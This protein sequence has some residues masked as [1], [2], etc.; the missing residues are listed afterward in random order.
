MYSCSIR[1]APASLS[2]ARPRASSGRGAARS[3]CCAA[4]GP[5]P[6]PRAWSACAITGNPAVAANSA[7]SPGDRPAWPRAWAPPVPAELEHREL[8]RQPAGAAPRRAGNRNASR[9]ASPCSARKI[10][11]ASSVG[12]Q[13]RRAADPARPGRAGRPGSVGSS[14][15]GCQKNRPAGN[16]NW[17]PV[18]AAPHAPRTPARRAG[19]GCGSRPRLPWCSTFRSNLSTTAGVLKSAARRSLIIAAPQ[20]TTRCGA[21]SNWYVASSTRGQSWPRSSRPRGAACAPRPGPSPSPPGAATLPSCWPPGRSEARDQRVVVGDL[22]ALPD[23][24]GDDRQGRG[25]PQVPDARLVA[26]ADHDDP[27]ARQRPPAGRQHLAGPLDDP[28]RA[29]AIDVIACSISGERRPRAF[30]CQSR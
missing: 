26:G 25:L 1:P 14:G 5:W 15:T 2:A 30:S 27:R 7:A 22:G 8:A 11:P 20:T 17:R 28:F 3:W 12:M 13:H 23:Q 21:P 9:S 29:V 4:A 16:G 6:P 18:P 24:P 10:A 19:P